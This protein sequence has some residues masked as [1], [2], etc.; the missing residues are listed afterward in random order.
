MTMSPSRLTY[1]SLGAGVQSSTLALMT[2]C[3]EFGPRPDFAIFADTQAEPESVYR[4]LDWLEGQLPFPVIRA[5]HG[6][7]AEDGLRLRDSVRTGLK[8][9]K[10]AVPFYV[11][12]PDGEMSLL[13]RRCTWD[14][15]IQVIQRE[16]RRRIPT[17][18]CIRLT[19]PHPVV[20]R[21]R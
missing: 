9:W 18:R 2:A 8:Y 10:R 15:K 17:T 5:T 13:T 11:K 3:E 14:Y 1:L 6:N 21:A 12:A 7:L 19:V 20:R 4:W 16:L